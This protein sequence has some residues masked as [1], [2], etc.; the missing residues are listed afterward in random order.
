[1]P[2]MP[3]AFEKAFDGITG[4][5]IVEKPGDYVNDDGLICCGTCG[6]PKQ[7]QHENPE[8]MRE[9]K[10][11]Y[12]YLPRLCRCE[13]EESERQEKAANDAKE[14]EAVRR[15]RAACFEFESDAAMTFDNDDMGNPK[16][17]RAC[18]RFVDGFETALQTGAGLMLFGAVGSGKSY[19][20]AEIANGVIDRGYRALYTSLARLM[21]RMGYDSEK[22]ATLDYLKGFDLVVL[23]DLGTERSTETATEKSYLIIDTLARLAKSGKTVTIFTTNLDPKAMERETDSALQKLYSRAIGMSQPVEVRHGD[24]RKAKKP[25]AMEFYKG[26]FAE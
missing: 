17:T 4:A 24:R 21:A 10:G 9:R 25:E 11:L 19:H 16:M 26:L 8:F 18:R 12:T 6:E 3:D 15:N 13:R 1:M 7:S 20:A 5:Q 23:D 14:A 22:A 2:S